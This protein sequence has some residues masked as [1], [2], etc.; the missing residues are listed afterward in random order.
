MIDLLLALSAGILFGFVLRHYPVWAKQVP[1]AI[2]VG[3][4]ALIFAM[5]LQVGGSSEVMNSI[6][7][8]GFQAASFAFITVCGS[9][10]FSVPLALWWKKK[11]GGGHHS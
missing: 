6:M 8:I 10:M 5:G 4:F 7:Q 2:T 11:S 9:V 1:V 3:L